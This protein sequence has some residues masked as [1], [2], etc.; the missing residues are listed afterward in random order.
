V[1]LIF[2]SLN[3]TKKDLTMATKPKTSKRTAPTFAR[4]GQEFYDHCI[5]EYDLTETEKALLLECCRTLDDLE[6]LAEVLERDGVTVKGSTGQTRTHP[7]LGEIRQHRL[8]LGKLLSLL[9][10]PDPEGETLPSYVQAQARAA[11]RRGA[12]SR[13]G[14]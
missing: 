9:E 6:A 11:G 1:F 14:N 2:P 4:R 12:N 13:W 10:L 7:A 8:A 5:S 3:P